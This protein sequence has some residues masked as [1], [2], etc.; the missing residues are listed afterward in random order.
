[1]KLQHVLAYTKYAR[2]NNEHIMAIG[3]KIKEKNKPSFW[4]LIAHE[5]IE[6]KK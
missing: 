3:K 1:M 2:F 4:F 5:P 6:F